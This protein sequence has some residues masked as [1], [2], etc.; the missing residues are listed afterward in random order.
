MK[1]TFRQFTDNGLKIVGT[2]NGDW[3]DFADEAIK[4]WIEDVSDDME[5]YPLGSLVE[6]M[7]ENTSSD[8]DL[9][10]ESLKWQQYVDCVSDSILHTN[11]PFVYN[12]KNKQITSFHKKAYSRILDIATQQC[13]AYF[14]NVQTV[15]TKEVK[16]KVL[17]TNVIKTKAKYPG[18]YATPTKKQP[19]RWTAYYRNNMQTIKIG[20]FS[21]QQEAIDAKQVIMQNYN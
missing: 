15:V 13:A 20:H 14:D 7:M 17:K 21:S 8:N 1:F 4:I 10:Y 18:V 12:G 16:K 3:N 11:A 19:N 2:S 6:T 5:K 9:P